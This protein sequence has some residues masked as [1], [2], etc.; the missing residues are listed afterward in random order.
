MKAK[1]T[2]DKSWFYEGVE[3]WNSTVIDGALEFA[4]EIESV[5]DI[6]RVHKYVVEEVNKAASLESVLKHLFVVAEKASE[7][8]HRHDEISTVYNLL[9][10]MQDY[11]E[12][13]Y[14]DMTEAQKK[15]VDD[16]F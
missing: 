1:F 9:Q 16:L 5:E 3:M 14:N 2:V 4:C 7:L 15:L 13:S 12:V 10:E 11:T 6:L 8:F